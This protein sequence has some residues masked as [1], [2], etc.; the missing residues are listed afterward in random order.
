MP[1]LGLDNAEC[2]AAFAWASKRPELLLEM[3]EP[4]S[5]FSS[6]KASSPSMTISM[7]S[8][9]VLVLESSRVIPTVLRSRM[10]KKQITTH[11]LKEIHD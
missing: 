8:D 9:N 11:E 1:D 2:A 7:E 10:E 5:D 3:F 6:S 4:D